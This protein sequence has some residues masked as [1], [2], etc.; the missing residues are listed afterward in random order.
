MQNNQGSLDKI[1]FDMFVGSL[2]DA[3]NAKGK[4]VSQRQRN[5]CTEIVTGP[6]FHKTVLAAVYCGLSGDVFKPNEIRTDVMR[7]DLLLPI[8][9]V[10][11]VYQEQYGTTRFAVMPCFK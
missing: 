1:V 2:V 4:Q 6:F 10:V 8:S 5:A 3:L 11:G 7:E 9:T